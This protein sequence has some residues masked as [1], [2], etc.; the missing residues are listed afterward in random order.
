MVDPDILPDSINFGKHTKAQNNQTSIAEQTY[1][2]T[3]KTRSRYCNKCSSL[4]LEVGKDLVCEKCDPEKVKPAKLPN[5]YLVI[6]EYSAPCKK[7]PEYESLSVGFRIV[8]LWFSFSFI[9]H[10]KL[11]DF[12]LRL[13][14]KRDLEKEYR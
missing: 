1:Q 14:S 10:L 2:A 3:K 9:K 7:K 12:L 8:W 13:P 6:I 5:R 11:Q 4:K